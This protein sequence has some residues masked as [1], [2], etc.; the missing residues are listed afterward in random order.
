MAR[1][2][3]QE[4]MDIF[5]IE[6]SLT[7]LDKQVDE[8]LD[9]PEHWIRRGR[10]QPVSNCASFAPTELLLTLSDRKTKVTQDSSELAALEARIREMEARL[11][12][13][14]GNKRPAIPTGGAPQ[15]KAQAAANA[16]PD[17]PTKDEAR[18]RPGTAKAS[19]SA[20]SSG[21]MP[22]TPGASEGEYYLVTRADL[23]DASR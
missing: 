2:F 18:S 16:A 17:L 19:Q 7:D 15:T 14:S 11:G 12:G 1:S 10:S 21:N 13:G 5:R 9:P 23:D 4:L 8:R 22:P 20:P 3:S 6:N